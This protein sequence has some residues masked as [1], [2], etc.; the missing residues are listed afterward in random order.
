MT[1]YQN[2]WRNN[3]ILELRLQIWNYIVTT[4]SLTAVLD[5]SLFPESAESTK[6]KKLRVV[7]VACR[8]FVNGDYVGYLTDK[9]AFHVACVTMWP[10]S[11]LGPNARQVVVAEEE[12]KNCYPGRFFLLEGWLDMEPVTIGTGS[13][14]SVKGLMKSRKSKERFTGGIHR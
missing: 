11:L 4:K 7:E 2:K 6:D 10:G 12:Q 8:N 1:S 14:Q 9:S 13:H 3:R 5:E